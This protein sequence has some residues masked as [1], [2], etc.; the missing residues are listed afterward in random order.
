MAAVAATAALIPGG[1]FLRWFVELLFDEAAFPPNSA[2][3]ARNL[4][5]RRHIVVANLSKFVSLKVQLELAKVVGDYRAGSKSL[6]EELVTIFPAVSP[7]V[8]LEAPAKENLTRLF[9]SFF[10]GRY[11][12]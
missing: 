5:T 1:N 3:R 8:N 11:S 9:H 10:S 7:C 4:H 6:F 2:A 12:F